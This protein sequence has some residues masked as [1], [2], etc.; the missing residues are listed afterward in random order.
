MN[1]TI[2]LD[3]TELKDLIYLGTALNDN[4]K[5]YHKFEYN[6][7]ILVTH[8][9]RFVRAV[10]HNK[11]EYLQMNV[12]HRPLICKIR[13]YVLKRMN[14]RKGKRPRIPYQVPTLEYT[15]QQTGT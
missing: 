12:T 6:R 13:H 9:E 15:L 3:T 2:V 4:A 10:E 11:V 14:H 1:T 5:K 7:T 8:D